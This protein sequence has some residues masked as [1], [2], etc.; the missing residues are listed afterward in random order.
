M[1][2]DFLWHLRGTVA[3]EGV[4]RGDATLDRLELLLKRQRK[5]AIE[6]TSSSITFDKQLWCSIFGGSW[7]AMVI[8]DHGQFWIEQGAGER[9]LRYDLRS[10]Q[11]MV[12]CLA[13][14]VIFFV[15][16]LSSGGLLQGLNRA[17]FAFAW[18]Y[19]MNILLALMR[20]P[21]L[22]RKAVRE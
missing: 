21:R 14:A 11:V 4:A 8:Y 20:V 5:P 16:G 15:V 18:L 7:L 6:R 12:I 3:L 1:M 17:S 13:A 19:G 10:L 9:R 2:I 22:I